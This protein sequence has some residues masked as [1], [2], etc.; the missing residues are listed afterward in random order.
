M[1]DWKTSL[2][3]AV[4]IAVGLALF[5]VGPEEHQPDGIIVIVTGLGFVAAKDGAK[6][7]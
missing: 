4:L 6:G 2:V 7:G 3:G 1:R 5:M